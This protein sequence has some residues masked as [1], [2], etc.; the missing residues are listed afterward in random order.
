MSDLEDTLI[1]DDTQ[2]QQANNSSQTN[3]LI[4]PSWFMDSPRFQAAVRAINATIQRYSRVLRLDNKFNNSLEFAQVLYFVLN[5]NSMS[6]S[7]A[8]SRASS[9]IWELVLTHNGLVDIP[10]TVLQLRTVQRLFL[11]NNVIRSIPIEISQIYTLH[12][13]DLSFNQITS[14][15]VEI[16]KL[17]ALSSLKL[18]HN[19]IQALPELTWSC[20]H[21]RTL[22]LDNN[23]LSEI[24]ISLISNL[25]ELWDLD[26][27]NNQI[28]SLPIVSN[29]NLKHLFVS[30]NKLTHIP[31][32]LV[33]KIQK[34]WALGNN[35]FQVDSTTTSTTTTTTTTTTLSPTTATTFR[36]IY[37]QKD[38]EQL[39][40]K[41]DQNTQFF[42]TLRELSA[43]AVR[44]HSSQLINTLQIPAELRDYLNSA[45][46]PCD[47]CK[48]V[49][50]QTFSLVFLTAQ[51]ADGQ[52]ASS[53]QVCSPQCAF[54]MLSEQNQKQ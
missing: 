43:R 37:Q 40:A 22:H 4:A 3:P 53:Y 50:F 23:Q 8:L 12:N 16:F 7:E 9:N 11:G 13:I 39:K 2:Q 36:I 17:P 49:F 15:P 28:Q 41:Q 19:Q 31:H 45:S 33:S 10:Q 38:L 46:A 30:H 21:I 32:Q 48:H 27:S 44:R 20:P 52:I 42:Q 5:S 25:P 34:I 1:V 26:L 47:H 14:I 35:W 24:P 6:E 51:V 54:Q 18:S 29:T